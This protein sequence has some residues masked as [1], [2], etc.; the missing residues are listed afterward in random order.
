MLLFSTNFARLRIYYNK[1]GTIFL[2]TLFLNKD[3]LNAIYAFSFSV[4]QRHS[5]LY[6]VPV[7]GCGLKSGPAWLRETRSS[8]SGWA[9]FYAWPIHVVLGAI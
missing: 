3:K 6:V 2:P 8:G 5:R 9:G 7:L 1:L 4:E